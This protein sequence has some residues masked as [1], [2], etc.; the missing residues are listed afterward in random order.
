MPEEKWRTRGVEL[1]K[2]VNKE[3]K[4]VLDLRENIHLFNL[5]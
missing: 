1:K 2:S 5:Q 4:S 3:K